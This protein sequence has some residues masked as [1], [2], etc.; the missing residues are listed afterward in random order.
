MMILQQDS[1][2]TGIGQF[3]AFCKIRMQV[4]EHECREA[5]HSMDGRCSVVGSVLVPGCPRLNVQYS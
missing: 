3:E 1:A 5:V 4:L 2:L